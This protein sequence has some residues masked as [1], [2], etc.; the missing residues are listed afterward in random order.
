MAE[1][2][3]KNNIILFQSKNI[4]R[5]WHEEEWFYSVIDVVGILI[6]KDYQSARTY[7]KKLAQRL[8]D[9]G[10]DQ[11]VTN[12]HQLKMQAA[13]GKMRLTH[14]AA[15]QT[16]LRI[17]QSIP[18]KK[19]EPFKLWLAQVGKERI[20]EINDPELAMDRMKSIYEQKGYPKEWIEKRTRG[21]AIRQELTDE[22]KERGAKQSIEYGILTN[23]I[24]KATFDLSIKD[25]KEIKDLDQKDNLRDHMVDL[26]LILTMLG[27]ATAT[28]IHKERDSQGFNELKIDAKDAGDIAGNT[29]KQIEE[30]TGTPV[31]SNENYKHLK[32]KRIKQ[33]KNKKAED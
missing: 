27:E 30:K 18:S 5:V 12:C 15:T 8:R 17:I 29:R 11:T 2:N 20:D 23:E 3:K 24:S 19:A 1:E 7:W 28:K 32:A 21:I 16:M 6:E 33:I 22:W 31:I 26:E 13:D 10:S 9:E 4:R 14:A 25:H